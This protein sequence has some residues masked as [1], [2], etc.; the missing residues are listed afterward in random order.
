[1]IRRSPP[2]TARES[3]KQLT[4]TPAGDAVQDAYDETWAAAQAR[5]VSMRPSVTDEVCM[6][7]GDRQFL[8]RAIVNLLSNAV[9][10]SP[11]DGS[12]ELLC[13]HEDAVAINC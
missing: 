5:S 12:V 11:Q 2:G 13:V 10:F 4:L 3:G 6:V 8:S 9:K 7:S 1:L